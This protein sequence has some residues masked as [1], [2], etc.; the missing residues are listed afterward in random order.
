MEDVYSLKS[1][2]RH[3][4]THH[5][6]ETTIFRF[7]I[8]LSEWILVH[9]GGIR[10]FLSLGLYR[11]HC[12]PHQILTFR[13]FNRVKR[14][15]TPDYYQCLLEDKLVFDRY[16]KSYGFPM[17]E[18]IGLV[19]VGNVKWFSTGKEEPVEN[20]LGHKLDGFLKML[21]KWGGQNV[22]RLEITDHGLFLDKQPASPGILKQMTMTGTYVLQKTVTQH[23]ELSRL[24]PSSVNT[25]R[26]VTI[27]DGI[28]AQNLAGFIRMGLENSLIDN[29]TRGGVGCAIHADGTL[30]SE[31]LNGSVRINHHPT[32]GVAFEGFRIPYYTEAIDLVRTMH[33][34]FHC[35]FII[36]WDIAITEDG[37]VVIEGNPVGDL[38]Y[39]QHFYTHIKK[40]FLSCAESYRR[41]RDAFVRE[42]VLE[43][44]S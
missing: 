40:T 9:R 1:I 5:R 38:I 28:T 29:I 23:P 21:T 8:R 14:R 4:W 44:R 20:L 16:M 37:P 22:H 24:N 31:G 2:F 25:V 39:E 36:A 10:S 42:F 26:L 15:L 41:N 18:M 27:H 12:K 43:D 19:Q 17:A 6:G 30:W 3:F 13:H 7:A 11:T 35:F 33:L 34:S 32:S